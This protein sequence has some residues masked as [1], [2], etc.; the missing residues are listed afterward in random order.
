[1]HSMVLYVKI[2]LFD[3]TART[4]IQQAVG[5]NHGR[6][7]A[8]RSVRS[9]IESFCC[10]PFWHSLVRKHRVLSGLRESDIRAFWSRETPLI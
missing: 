2:S 10:L 5:T 8:P 7:S 6:T 9:L 4:I 3:G 1:M